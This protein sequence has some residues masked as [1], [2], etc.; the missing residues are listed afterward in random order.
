VTHIPISELDA[1][2]AADPEDFP[3][4]LQKILA[5]ADGRLKTDNHL[6]PNWNPSSV[7]DNIPVA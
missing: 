7:V 5:T 2:I 4:F 6:Y 1:R 3:S